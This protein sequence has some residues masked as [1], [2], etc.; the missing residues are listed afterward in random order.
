MRY[1]V[2]AYCERMTTEDDR[3]TFINLSSVRHIRWTG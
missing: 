1:F 2:R 3:E